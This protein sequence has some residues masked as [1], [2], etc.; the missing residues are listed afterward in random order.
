[1]SV[2]TITSNVVY[3]KKTGNTPDGRKAGE[4]FAPGATQC[5]A[6][7]KKG[8][9]S[10]LSSVAKIPYDCCKDGISNTFSIVPKSLGKEPEDQNRNL[11]SMLDGYAM[12]CGSPL[13]Y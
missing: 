8:A 9:L 6:V 12:Q 10:S 1:M 13:K 2:L 3:G 7:T 5:M 11:T 4:P